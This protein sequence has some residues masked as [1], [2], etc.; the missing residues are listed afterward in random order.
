MPYTSDSVVWQ[1]SFPIPEKEAKVLS[2]LGPHALK[3]EAC[4]RTQ[5]L[6]S[7][8]QI[9]QTTQQAMVSGYPVYDRALLEPESLEKAGYFIDRV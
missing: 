5:W 6:D 4:R 1:L 2:A 9:L 7:I 3:D 8:T